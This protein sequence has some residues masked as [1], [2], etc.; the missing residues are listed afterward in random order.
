M[1]LKDMTDLIRVYDAYKRM[2]HI[3]ELMMGMVMPEDD[4]I[5]CELQTVEE[6]IARN[7]VLYER[8][9]KDPM[10]DMADSE[11]AEVLNDK[12]LTAEQRALRILGICNEA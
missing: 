12:R 11:H 7:S 6:V 8:D 1:E 5:M 4:S 3:M 9:S 2:D 10:F